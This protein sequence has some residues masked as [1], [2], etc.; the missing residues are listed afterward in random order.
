MYVFTVTMGAIIL[1]KK[2][3]LAGRNAH[4]PLLCVVNI[5]L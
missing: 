4:L 1:R 2:T 5:E 3:W